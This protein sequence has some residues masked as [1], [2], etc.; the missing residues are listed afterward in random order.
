M[1]HPTGQGKITSH[2]YIT[3]FDG[4]R[5]LAVIGVIVY[6]ILPNVLKGGY[7][8]VPIFLL[9]A[10]YLVTNQMVGK[11]VNGQSIRVVNFYCRRLKRLY[12][13]LI[14]ML[15]LTVTY[16]TLF[17]RN[18]FYQLKSIFITN[19]LFI[20]NWWEVIYDQSYFDRFAGES[21]FTHLW[22]LGVEV[23]FYLIWPLLLILL[24]KLL[25]NKHQVGHIVLALSIVSAI[26]MAVLYDPSHI[27]RVYYGTDTRAFS[28]L[29][30]A[31]LAFIWP[32]DQLRYQLKPQAKKLIDITGIIALL[33]VVMLY[34]VLPGEAAFTYYG[35]MFIFSIFAMILMGVIAH[36]GSSLSVWFTNPIFTWIGKRSYGIYV[37]QFPVLI[38]Y[39]SNVKNIGTHPLINAIIEIGIILIISE[40]S[41]RF[42]EAPMAKFD[43]KNLSGKLA[44]FKNISWQWLWLVPTVI[45]VGIAIFGIIKSPSE[46]PQSALEKRIEQNNKTIKQHN[47]NIKS[48]KV[49]EQPKIGD[50]TV[51]KKYGLSNQQVKAARQLKV[52]AIGDSVLADSA[53]NLQEIFPNIYISSKVG[54]Q[55]YEAP[56]IVQSLKRNGH[57][58]NVVVINLGSNGIITDSDAKSILKTIGPDRQVYWV[59]THVPSKAWQKPVNKEIKKI[60]KKY[61]NVHVIDWYQYSIGHP[62]WFYSDN[63][64]TNVD[65]NVKFAKLITGKLLND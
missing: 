39:E 41:Y 7:L 19:V 47:S 60:D 27:N 49:D 59:T 21:P 38:F 48:G 63:V 40:L 46:K 6:H 30:G 13:T 10:G 51:A 3:G 56:E 4:L 57:L 55:S 25:K 15:I 9:L 32:V 18:L 1:K 22:T 35:G 5:A 45:I 64:H 43:M 58:A 20:Y 44:K 11:L 26:L 54:R 53:V 65:G 62:E 16:I 12:P 61:D 17:Q 52:T 2:R 50:G 23:Q 34:F 14:S 28:F 31:W 8:G 33:A 36:P 42:I 29:L 24:F 37:Y